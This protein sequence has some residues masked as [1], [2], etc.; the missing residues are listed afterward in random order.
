MQEG[1]QHSS[2]NSPTHL[3][4]EYLLSV[5]TCQTLCGDLDF[6][7]TQGGCGSW[8]AD[9]PL[10][11]GGSMMGG[12]VEHRPLRKRTVEVL[13]YRQQ[14]RG[15]TP[16]RKGGSPNPVFL[17]SRASTIGWGLMELFKAQGQSHG[18]LL[19]RFWAQDG[20][21]MLMPAKVSP[22]LCHRLPGLG[23]QPQIQTW[24]G[25]WSWTKAIESA[26][27]H[28]SLQETGQTAEW[29]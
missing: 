20:W 23:W 27:L 6:S 11:Y 12:K 15:Q 8:A 13:S 14:L 16:C 4:T 28:L 2:V 18:A 1:W 10:Q 26:P 19:S 29:C 7:N 3:F 21:A 5:F 9:R 24:N 22:S 25:A 17:L